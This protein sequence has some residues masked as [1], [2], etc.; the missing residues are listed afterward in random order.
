MYIELDWREAF[1]EQRK[2]RI[3]PVTAGSLLTLSPGVALGGG[4]IIVIGAAAILA[5]HL[6]RRLAERGDDRAQDIATWTIAILM[7]LGVIGF[8]WLILKNPL[9]ELFD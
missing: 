7:T 6:E 4:I 8:A 9:W 5:A 3:A 1:A 2:C